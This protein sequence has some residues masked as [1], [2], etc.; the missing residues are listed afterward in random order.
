MKWADGFEF[1]P[2]IGERD[3]TRLRAAGSL[4]ELQ[5]RER[6]TCTRPGLTVARFAAFDAR[7]GQVLDPA[8]RIVLRSFAE[9]GVPTLVD[10]AFVTNGRPPK[11]RAKYVRIHTAYHKNIAELHA[12]GTVW[13]MPSNELQDFVG[14]QIHFNANHW[15]LKPGNPAGRSIQDTTAAEDGTWPLNHDGVKEQAESLWGKLRHPTILQLITEVILAART[16][17][18][19][20]LEN[21]EQLVLWKMDLK[22]A[23]NLLHVSPTSVHLW[24]FQLLDGLTMLFPVG[25]FGWT[26]WPHA[27]G[28]LTLCLEAAVTSVLRGFV[29]AYVDDFMGC[30]LLKDVNRDMEAARNVFVLL[31]GEGSVAEP[32]SEFGSRLTWIGWDIDLDIV[33]GCLAIGASLLLKAINVF[34]TVDHTKVS[35]RDLEKL[36]SYAGR[37]SL[38]FPYLK[39][40]VAALYAEYAGRQRLL[41]FSMSDEGLEALEAWRYF[42]VASH[43]CPARFFRS[44]QSFVHLEVT[45]T[46][47]WDASLYGIGA[48]LFEGDGS[49]GR[50]LRIVK[51]PFSAVDYPF[52]G[53]SRFQNLSEYLG[54]TVAI[55]L[56]IRLGFSSCGLRIVGD[57]ITALQWTTEGTYVSGPHDRVAVLQ[58]LLRSDAEIHISKRD[59][60][61]GN[62]NDYC[63]NLSR[64]HDP[65]FKTADVSA[66]A[67]PSL[68]CTLETEPWITSLLHLV[69]A[70]SWPYCESRSAQLLHEASA[71]SAHIASLGR[72]TRLRHQL[73]TRGA[74]ISAE[75]A[76]PVVSPCRPN[77]DLCDMVDLR[78]SPSFDNI[79][80]L[81]FPRISRHIAVSD[82]FSIIAEAYKVPASVLSLRLL[83]SRRTLSLVR[84]ASLPLSTLLPLLHDGVAVEWYGSL[85][86]G[87]C[88]PTSITAEEEDLVKNTIR[89]AVIM[90]R[91][92]SYERGWR[93]WVAFL[94]PRQVSPNPFLHGELDKAKVQLLILFWHHLRVQK[95]LTSPGPLLSGVRHYCRMQQE[96]TACFHHEALAAAKTSMRESART[97]SLSRL[98]GEG[99]RRQRSVPSSEFLE[100]IRQWAFDVPTSCPRRDM[101]IRSQFCTYLASAT[102]FNFGL[103]SVNVVASSQR[104]VQHAI[105]AVD[106]AFEV[107]VSGWVSS[108]ELVTWMH[109]QR[110]HSSLPQTLA[111]VLRAR[112]FFH[113]S[114]IHRVVGATEFVG[115]RSP[116]EARYLDDLTWWTGQ[117]CGLDVAN[118]ESLLF[119]RGAAYL[120]P[121]G[122][123]TIHSIRLCRRADITSALKMAAVA[124]GCQPDFFSSKS[125]RI[126]AATLLRALGKDEEAIRAFGNWT[127]SASYIYQHNQGGEDRPLALS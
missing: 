72:E 92:N 75:E 115:R 3:M 23:F 88:T 1:D 54:V 9:D 59:W 35:R 110:K 112:L 101:V 55:A 25:C 15:V 37:F 93:Y 104:S 116:A 119:S 65:Y 61:A 16:R 122:D 13:L 82:L 24:A 42:L 78:V 7:F 97:S 83:P 31:L 33:S 84:D 125:W 20:E 64:R 21:G 38:V 123:T 111:R 5:R 87:S 28:V 120:S 51:I 32:K 94:Q 70:W 53:D 52:D 17:F 98:T 67:D 100:T 6:A 39:P 127:S 124:L 60:I 10:A 108:A 36:S 41:S 56:A 102:M 30:C 46:L 29:R 58:A 73:R 22:G 34:F 107:A 76:V 103:R 95:G 68:L 71:L 57:S 91:G 27:F 63:D 2:G 11:P 86:G 81:T 18:T 80:R 44:L 45:L 118:P 4:A 114:K 66:D 43:A 19:A 50:I 49:E 126:A 105:R 89:S 113:S 69:S 121:R 96:D 79:P 8:L 48:V 99:S 77:I 117:G 74:S 26:N 14:S 12:K 62:D 47:V 90:D 40:F 109:E 106:V 85:F